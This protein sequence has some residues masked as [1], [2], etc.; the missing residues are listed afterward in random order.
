MFISKIRFINLP[1]LNSVTRV[2]TRIFTRAFLTVARAL[3]I[4]SH[5][6][7]IKSKRPLYLNTVTRSLPSKHYTILEVVLITMSMRVARSCA[8]ATAY[9]DY[10]EIWTEHAGHCDRKHAIFNL[11]LASRSRIL[12]PSILYRFS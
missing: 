1:N 4:F 2:L 3:H 9:N 12:Y 5:T 8:I 10:T 11:P 7:Y 6:Q